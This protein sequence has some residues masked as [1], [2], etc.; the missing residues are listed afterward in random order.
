[1]RLLQ[2]FCVFPVEL[3]GAGREWLGQ[4]PLRPQISGSTQSGAAPEIPPFSA[5]Q[6]HFAK[7]C[8]HHLSRTVFASALRHKSDNNVH[9]SPYFISSNRPQ[10]EAVG[11]APIAA[12]AAAQ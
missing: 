7:T 12:V 10:S 3:S 1:M 8:H 4:V 6:K 9:I 5:L 2:A 11:L